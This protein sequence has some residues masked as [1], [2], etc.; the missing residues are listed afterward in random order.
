MENDVYVIVL[1]GAGDK[2]FSA[3]ANIKMLSS[4]DPTFKYY[5]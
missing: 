5:F 4:V 1:T 2:F 3:G